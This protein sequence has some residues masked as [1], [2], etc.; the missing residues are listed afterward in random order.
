MREFGI[1]CTHYFDDFTFVA[2]AAVAQTM[3]DKAKDVLN[4]LGWSVKAD[5][6][7]PLAES[8]QALGVLFNLSECCTE[9][10]VLVVKNTEDRIK[11]IRAEVRE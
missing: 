2:P 5:T 7:L 9:V 4:L 1:P 3:I 6:D 11:E 8:F 10:P